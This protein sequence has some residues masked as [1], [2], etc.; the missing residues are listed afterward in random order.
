MPS[1]RIR[2]KDPRGLLA[3]D[4][5]DILSAIGPR[6]ENS[7]WAVANESCTGEPLMVV[8]DSG[9]LDELVLF[10]RTVSGIQ[11]LEIL[12]GVEQIIWGEFS[13]FE[14][15]ASLDPWLVIVAFDSSWFE[16]R[17]DDEPTLARLKE[18]FVDVSPIYPSHPDRITG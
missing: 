4:L 1:V 3:F 15:T 16:V 12:K 18:R 17:T 5:R 9:A 13:G 7:I 10:K 8:G 14:T 6:A 11:L 2:D